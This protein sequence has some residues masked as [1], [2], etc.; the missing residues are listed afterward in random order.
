MELGWETAANSDDGGAPTRCVGESGVTSSGC[1]ASR[2]VSSRMSA[3]Y[4]ASDTSGS[5]STW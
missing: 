2:D 1:S 4:S 5:S 3:S